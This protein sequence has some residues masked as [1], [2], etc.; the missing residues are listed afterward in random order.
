[1][2]EQTKSSPRR[3][4]LLVLAGLALAHLSLRAPLPAAALDADTVVYE[5]RTGSTI[6]DGCRDCDRIPILRALGGQFLLKALPPLIGAEP[7]EIID[8][9]FESPEGEYRVK[10]VGNYS[11]IVTLE[12][13]QR[14]E[15]KLEVNGVEGISL[16][17]EIVRVNF[18]F[19]AIEIEATE[20]GDR[21]PAHMYTIRIVAAPKV[22]MVPY[23]L[24]EGSTFTDDC[25]PCGRPTIP[26]P[27]KGT[28]LLGEI[29]GSPNPTST[30]FVDAVDFSSADPIRGYRLSGF[31]FYR[32]GGEVALV[33][34]MRLELAVA[35]PGGATS[36]GNILSSKDPKVPRPFPEIEIELAHENPAS[37]THVY[38]LVI[39]ARPSG[40]PPVPEFRRGDANAD[41]KVDISDAVSTLLWL[42][43]GLSEPPC[44]E[45]VDADTSGKIDLTDAIYTL[46]YL[47][48][49]GSSPPAPG[50]EACG[51]APEPKLG[52]ASYTAC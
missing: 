43:A 16:A 5:L 14:V 3:C 36:P 20:P 23:E 44:L 21:D 30:Y 19:P 49:G 34:S 33:Q 24:L 9:E 40:A 6:L 8:L 22:P 35:D 41:G 7:Y 13:H 38:S 10:G 27:L 29:E 37:E 12:S 26:I 32:Q 42:F 18:P 52:C 51:P 46:Q 17:S 1:M 31:G 39:I 2:R 11:R 15:L 48:Q 25:L 50:P 28:F 45:A 47:F 4:S